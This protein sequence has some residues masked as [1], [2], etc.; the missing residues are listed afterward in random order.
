MPHFAD[1]LQYLIGGITSGSIYAIVAIGFAIIYNATEII[2]FAQGEFVMLGALIYISFSRFFGFPL[3]V[4]FAFSVVSVTI[5]GFIMDLLVI[6]PVKKPNPISLIIITIGASIFI[7]GIAMRLWGKDPYPSA[8]PFSS[9]TPINFFGASIMPQTLWIIGIT[10]IILVIL[11]FFFEYTIIGKAVK[12]C[13]INRRAASLLGIKAKK[14]VLISFGLSGA[15]GAISGIIIAPI[16]F[17]SY[18]MGTMLGLKGFCGA[19]IGGLGSI[20][21]A[22]IGGFSLGIFESLGAGLISSDFKDAIAFVI[23]LAVLFIRPS[24]IVNKGEIKRV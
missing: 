4:S 12:A 22:I 23:L 3:V 17:A 9:E 2:N 16:T 20:P 21:G 8:D 7:Q 18:K 24:G 13:A 11:H 5:I 15:L 14:M 6:R 1:I 10:L 19:V